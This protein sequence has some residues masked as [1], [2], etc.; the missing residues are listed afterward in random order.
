MAEEPR[1]AGKRRSD[2]QSRSKNELYAQSPALR[3]LSPQQKEGAVVVRDL[4]VFQGKLLLDGL[5]DLV[6]IWA[7]IGAAVLDVIKPTEERGRRFYAVMRTAE[8]FDRWLNLYGAAE[9]VAD[10]GE[11]PFGRG[12]ADSLLGRLE[13]MVLGDEGPE[14]TKNPASPK[15]PRDPRHREGTDPERPAGV[16]PKAGA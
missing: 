10:P 1:N 9:F 8:R 2:R 4:L 7:S 6:M 16:P 5:M 11:G 15:L 3:K 14:A 12:G 13:E